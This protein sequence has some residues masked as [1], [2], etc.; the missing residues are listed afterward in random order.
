M[1]SE[2]GKESKPLSLAE[3]A[4]RKI[5]L[6]VNPKEPSSRFS[7]AFSALPTPREAGVR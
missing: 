7:A 6:F 4:E 2:D 5:D 1:K 3:N